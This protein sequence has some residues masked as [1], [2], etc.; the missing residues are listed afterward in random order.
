LL[1]QY[2]RLTTS[3]IIPAI[4]ES[5]PA[6]LANIVCSIAMCG[7]F[8]QWWGSVTAVNLALGGFLD[9]LGVERLTDLRT[10]PRSELSQAALI[11]L[12]AVP[13]R[14][15][16]ECVDII[17]RVIRITEYL[18]GDWSTVRTL[19]GAKVRRLVRGITQEPVPALLIMQ[20]IAAD[21]VRPLPSGGAASCAMKIGIV[22]TWVPEYASGGHRA[23]REEALKV[24]QGLSPEVF[25]AFHWWGGGGSVGSSVGCPESCGCCSAATYCHDLCAGLI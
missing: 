18:H 9:F 23:V 4:S 8:A 2:E 14:R 6:E 25:L 1:E 15:V 7:D 21:Y 12:R 11:C 20:A 19:D 13:E 24:L 16:T 3:D 5:S 17:R 22:E 10:R